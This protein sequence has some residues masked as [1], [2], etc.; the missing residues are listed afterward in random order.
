MVQR[1]REGPAAG[2]LPRAP[3]TPRKDATVKIVVMGDANADWLA[4]GV[5]DAFSEKTEI[6]I[7]RKHRTYS[8]LIRYDQHRG[9]EWP[10]VAREII[11]AKKPKFIV[12]MTILRADS[13]RRPMRALAA[14]T[15]CMPKASR[16]EPGLQ[17]LTMRLL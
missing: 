16:I 8:G 7:V 11:A 9:N 12:M 4:Y 14:L 1:S 17:T 13:G 15:F 5:E 10:Q 3:A 2:L 6:G